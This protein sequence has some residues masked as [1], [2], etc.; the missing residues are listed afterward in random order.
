MR[1]I[2]EILYL[3]SFVCVCAIAGESLESGWTPSVSARVVVASKYAAF[4]SGGILYDKPVI[5]S[6]LF[7]S[8][9]NG[10]YADLWN[11]V[12]FT[13][14]DDNFGWEQ[15][16]GIGWSGP[17]SALGLNGFA[18]DMT[19]DLGITYFDEPGLLTLGANDILYNHV[20]LSKAFNLLTVFVDFKSYV[21]MPH[22]PYSGGNLYD[23]GIS[24]GVS[25]FKDRLSA[26]TS[27]ALV[28]DDGGFGFDNGLLLYGCAELD[29][30]LTKHLVLILPQV[31]YYAPITLRDSRSL[32]AV[33]S[34]GLGYQF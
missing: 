21:P 1:K 20:K 12:P 30:L 26:S 15:D 14:H 33:I 5:Q 13:G 32:D 27:L 28:Y 3:V 34:G 22:S 7:V 18:S 4:G 6:D 8:F 29:W 10:F 9:R 25:V 2:I 24:R 23:V 19:L 17:L 11:S 16:L 31:S